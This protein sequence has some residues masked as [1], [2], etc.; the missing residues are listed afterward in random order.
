MHSARFAG[1]SSLYPPARIPPPERAC[2][3]L[4]NDLA[5]VVFHPVF[6]PR[7]APPFSARFSSKTGRTVPAA[8]PVQCSDFSFI[9]QNLLRCFTLMID[10]AFQKELYFVSRF[11]LLTLFQ[12]RC[13]VSL[14]GA[15]SAPVTTSFRLRILRACEKI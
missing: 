13:I 14:Q 4:E 11:L 5:A 1:I 10:I 9:N 12:N 6:A 15:G 8:R 2:I 7:T 3:H